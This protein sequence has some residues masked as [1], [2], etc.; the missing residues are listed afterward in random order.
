MNQK[1]YFVSRQ[2]YYYSG[3]AV[4][5]I[6]T[7]SIDSA[8]ADMLGEKFRR[9]G[10]GD[11]YADPR[12]AASA[13]IAILDAWK[14]TNPDV[15][16]IAVGNFSMG[17]EGE[18]KDPGEVTAW[19]QEKYDD[20]PKCECGCGHVIG[21]EYCKWDDFMFVNENHYET[22]LGEQPICCNKCDQEL[23][24]KDAFWESDRPYH[25]DCWYDVFIADE[26]EEVEYA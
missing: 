5:E 16:G 18:P 10:E 15:A 20:L 1:G 6:A 14:K 17:F 21:A 2:Q 22:W 19:A 4:V 23:I 3:D 25:A 12:E 8:G 9:E 11:T 7:N 13:A 24:T 26:D